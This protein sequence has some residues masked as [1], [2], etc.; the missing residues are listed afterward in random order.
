MQRSCEGPEAELREEALILAQLWRWLK[1]EGFKVSWTGS[2][3]G[4]TGNNTGHLAAGEEAEL[5]LRTS[6]ERVYSPILAAKEFVFL[7]KVKSVATFCGRCCLGCLS[8]EEVEDE[9]RIEDAP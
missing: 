4:N 2:G 5:R 6:A 9:W 8:V 3:T 7:S 1:V